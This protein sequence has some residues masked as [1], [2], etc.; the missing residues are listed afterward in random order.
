[1]SRVCSF[2]RGLGIAFRKMTNPFIEQGFLLR[3]KEHLPSRMERDT[4]FLSGDHAARIP[5]IV[6][7]T[8]A[9]GV[10]V[11]VVM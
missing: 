4:V 3:Q 5:D 1:M 10:G 2:Q 6:A 9:S 11:N 8:D 7:E